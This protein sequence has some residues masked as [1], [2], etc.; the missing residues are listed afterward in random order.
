MQNG[1]RVVDGTCEREGAGRSWGKEIDVNVLIAH[2]S[3]RTR[4]ALAA[5]LDSNDFTFVEAADGNSALESLMQEDPPRLALIDWDLPD[6]EGPELCRILRDFHLGR[7]PY[8]ILLT[9]ERPGRDMKSGLVA[10]ASDFVCTPASSAELRARVEFGK[11]VVESPWGRRR[12]DDRQAAPPAAAGGRAEL[13]AMLTNE[14]ASV[15]GA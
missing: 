13:S 2:E 9:P 15:L 11:H 4:V 7:P 6:V 5:A 10:G 3:E 1:N 12:E 14:W 8:V